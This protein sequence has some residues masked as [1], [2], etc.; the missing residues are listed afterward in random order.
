MITN[1]ELLNS[2]NAVVLYRIE[3]K[4]GVDTLDTQERYK[5][6]SATLKYLLN[7]TTAAELLKWLDVY[8]FVYRYRPQFIPAGEST[9]I[10]DLFTGERG[11]RLDKED[12]QETT[13]E[14]WKPFIT[15]ESGIDIYRS[16]IREPQDVPPEY[17]DSENPT[18]EPKIFDS[19]L[20][21]FLSNVDNKTIL[22]VGGAV[23]LLL[24]LRGARG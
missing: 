21:G 13:P 8:K 11:S 18:E 6:M 14:G 2:L 3:Q 12:L 9:Y 24:F 15:H 20:G 23:L 16:V 22:Y 10:Y 7:D 5:Q 4:L 17:V 19:F 1:E